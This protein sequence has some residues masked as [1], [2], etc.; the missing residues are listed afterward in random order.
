[1]GRSEMRP[2][3]AVPPRF[4]KPGVR[5]MSPRPGASVLK[6]G[7]RRCTA[8]LGPPIIMQ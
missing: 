3:S 8:S 2:S 1:M 7:S 6:I 4:S 5:G